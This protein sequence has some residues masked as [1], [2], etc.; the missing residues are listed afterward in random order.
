MSADGELGYCRQFLASCGDGAP[1]MNRVRSGDRLDAAV[2]AL[3]PGHDGTVAEA[4][5]E[6]HPHRHASFAANDDA[7]QIRR[8]FPNRHEFNNCDSSRFGRELRFEYER[9]TQ[10]SSTR[11]KNGTRWRQ[12]PA[13]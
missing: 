6:I 1:Q 10:I 9:V 4:K 3:N 7:D 5:R 12:S 13:S 2:L 11:F 8:R